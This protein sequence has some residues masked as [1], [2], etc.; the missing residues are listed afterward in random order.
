MMISVRNVLCGIAAALVL[1][2]AVHAQQEVS[3]EELQAQIARLR[4]QVAELEQ[5]KAQLDRLERQMEALQKAQKAADPAVTPA[6]KG[7]RIAIDGR[8]FAG[9]VGTQGH[10]T[11]PYRSVDIPDAKIRFAF[12]PND[13]IT[14]I[15]C[16]SNN[17]AASGG[18]DH[19]YVDIKDWGGALPGHT[20][21]L[22]KHKIDIGVETWTDNPVESIVVTNAV[23]HVSG[24]DEGINLRGPLTRGRLPWTYSIELL[25]GT[26]GFTMSAQDIT[27]GAKVGGL[28]SD[29]LYLAI[30]AIRTGNLVK[31]DGTLDKP[32]LNIAEV[33]DPPAG[34]M[35]WRRSIWEIDLRYNYGK[36][37]IKSI[38]GSQPDVPWQAAVAF[39]RLVDD[40]DGAPDR[41]GSCGFAEVLL[42]L[43]PRTYLGLRYSQM[44]LEDGATAKLGGS[45]VAVREY[46]RYSLGVGYRLS[47][48]THLKTEYTIND[49]K[50]G[51]SKPE[52]NQFA[53]GVATKF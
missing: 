12:S 5:V 18:F 50:G 14:V 10:G 27:I 6:N 26:Q 35:G 20:I 31:R 7:A 52:L 33:F 42:N 11:F 49:A 53:M 17:R 34:A 23:S 21:R 39:G 1:S 45:P 2:A 36:E 30:S 28:V 22:G 13:Y 43:S 15:N 16:Y 8:L 4:Q 44:N 40:A 47:H 24:Y 19:F 38:V 41:K 25:N 3:A 9:V 32:D 48:L 29:R 51:S 37:G 46:R